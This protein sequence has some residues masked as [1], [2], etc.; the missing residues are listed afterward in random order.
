MPR[1][2]GDEGGD[3]GAGEAEVGEEGQDGVGVGGGLEVGELGGGLEG[4]S[5]GEAAGGDEVVLHG[6][7]TRVGGNGGD[8]AVKREDGG[9]GRREQLGEDILAQAEHG[10]LLPAPPAAR[11]G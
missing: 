9:G 10:V 5:F 7:A 2:L 11:G 8:E 3:I 6:E 4:L 1:V